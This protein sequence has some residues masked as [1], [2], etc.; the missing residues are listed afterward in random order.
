MIKGILANCTVSDLQ[1][2]EAWYTVLFER[3]PDHRP[4]PGLLEWHLGQGYGVQVWYEPERAG[5]S[6][7]VLD[8][9]DLESDAKRLLSS[10]IAHHGPQRGAGA[11]ILQLED[12]DGNRIVLAGPLAAPLP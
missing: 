7:F 1:R 8:V 5:N 11:H 4:M 9:T 10:G 6:T 12:P 3:A 2:A